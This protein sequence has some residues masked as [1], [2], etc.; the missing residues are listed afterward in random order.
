MTPRTEA[1]AVNSPVVSD[2]VTD[3]EWDGLVHRENN[4]SFC[5]LWGWRRI[6]EDVMGHECIFR[7]ARDGAGAIVGVLPLARVRSL[8]FG[9]H[10]VSMPFLNYGGAAGTLAARSVL[11][12]WALQEAQRRKVDSLLLRTRHE[13]SADWPVSKSKV[14]VVLPLPPT[15]DELW[16]DAFTAKFR[17]K[18]KRPQRDGMV[19]QFGIEHIR[20]FYDVFA[21]NM[22]DL[23]TP[24]V[25][26]QFFD[27]IAETFPQNALVAV[28]YWKD[29]PVAGGFG[30]IWRDE[31]EMTWS[32]S[33]KE[34]RAQ[35]PNMLLYWD[36]MRELIGRGVR[37][38]NFGRST[39]GTGTH[40]FKQS[41][42]G[43]DEPLPWVQWPAA[44]GSH[45]ENRAAQLAAS[46]WRMLPLRVTNT[47]GPMLARQLPW[48]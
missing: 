3:S 16:N 21:Q 48:W 25:P 5:H 37:S 12:T 13:I 40:E 43:V 41:W 23:G 24:V 2:Q 45:D 17:N 46:V 7:V 11:T 14:T 20:G 36:F 8:V 47:L 44:S 30:F 31:F 27:R 9:D 33:R 28:T 42:G 34:L 39:P 29:R 38:F 26:R 15:A 18:I 4:A 10:L 32:S 1:S 6:I 35:K 19:T 22:R